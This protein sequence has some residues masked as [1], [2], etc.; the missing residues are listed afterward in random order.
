MTQAVT[1]TSYLHSMPGSV[2]IIENLER[3]GSEA[4]KE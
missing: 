1:K 2:L 4:V 3:P